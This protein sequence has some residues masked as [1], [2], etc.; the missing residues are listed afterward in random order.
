MPT[1]NTGLSELIG[2]CRIIATLRPRMRVMSA[3]GLAR[4]SSPSRRTWPPTIRA[5]GRGWSRTRLRHVML[6][7]EPDSPTSPS[8]SPSARLND[9]PST[10]RIT[11]QRV[12]MCVRRSRTSTA[13]GAAVGVVRLVLLATGAPRAGTSLA[14]RAGSELAELRVEGVPE[15][16]T[17]EVERKDDQQDGEPGEAGHPP[18]AGHELAPLGDHRAPGRR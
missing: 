18:G 3:S 5:A 4:R 9:T 7:P 14:G 17:E 6:L 13:G 16:V 10:A 8:V 1:E 12:T 15:P 2:S 11:P